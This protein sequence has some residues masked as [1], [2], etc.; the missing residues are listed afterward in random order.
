MK[1][2]A[3][4]GAGHCRPTTSAMALVSGMMT[5]LLWGRAG[6]GRG[7]A[8]ADASVVERHQISCEEVRVRCAFGTGCSVALHNYFAKCD[9]VL[10]ADSTSCPESCLYALVALTSTEDGKRMLDVSFLSI[11][12]VYVFHCM[13]CAYCVIIT[14]SACFAKIC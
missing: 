3:A 9:K 12:I 8:Y 5:L 6:G 14:R 2:A 10:Q 7:L 1:T 11:R 4:A 13:C